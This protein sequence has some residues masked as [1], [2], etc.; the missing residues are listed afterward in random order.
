MMLPRPTAAFPH[1]RIRLQLATP[2][3]EPNA[4]DFV[5]EE[6]TRML[7]NTPRRTLCHDAVAPLQQ[8]AA[9][10]ADPEAAI[11]IGQQ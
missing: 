8:P 11:A 10:G 7:A 2:R 5:L 1:S 4:T 3:R 6:W 9:F